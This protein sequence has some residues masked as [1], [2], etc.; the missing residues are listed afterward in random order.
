MVERQSMEGIT[1]EMIDTAKK[2]ME[3]DRMHHLTWPV[4]L[5]MAIEMKKLSMPRVV[6]SDNAIDTGDWE[7]RDAK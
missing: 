2:L 1:Q 5:E 6:P 7:K 4:A 3:P